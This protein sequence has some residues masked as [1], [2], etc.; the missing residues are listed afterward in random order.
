MDPRVCPIYFSQ[1]PLFVHLLTRPTSWIKML[2][3]RE[4]ELQGKVT[5]LQ[6]TR[7]PFETHTTG[8][9]IPYTTIK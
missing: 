3:G 7:R 4:V 6:R 2:K 9:Q 1:E 8:L 5:Q